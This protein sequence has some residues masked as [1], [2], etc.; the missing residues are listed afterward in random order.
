MKCQ[1]RKV[2]CACSHAAAKK[3]KLFSCVCGWINAGRYPSLAGLLARRVK[4]NDNRYWVG[5][6]ES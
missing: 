2:R 5:G 6:G 1:P 4:P 3:H